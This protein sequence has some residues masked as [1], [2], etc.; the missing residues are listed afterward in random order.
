VK[1]Q[2]RLS[3]LILLLIFILA[4]K[5]ILTLQLFSQFQYQYQTFYHIKS[6]N[7]YISS[8]RAVQIALFCSFFW[9]VNEITVFLD[10][11]PQMGFHKPTYNVEIAYGLSNNNQGNLI[12]VKVDAVSGHV[13]NISY[14]QY[15]IANN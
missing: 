5:T 6:N 15:F 11:Y 9:D 1:I 8:D 4:F 13:K 7:S 12:S 2:N 10:V 3:A 14:G